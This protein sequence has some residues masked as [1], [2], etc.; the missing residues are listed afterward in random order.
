MTRYKTARQVWIE[1]INE[2]G[3]TVTSAKESSLYVA[4]GWSV[5][6]KSVKH[7]C[8][9]SWVWTDNKTKKC[10]LCGEIRSQAES[11]GNDCSKDCIDCGGCM[12][13]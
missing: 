13:V 11:E 1:V 6:V 3:H 5:R 2:N 4:P 9:H 8:I 12:E 7:R 10:L